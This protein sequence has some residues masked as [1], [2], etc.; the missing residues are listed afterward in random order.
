MAKID[1]S[2]QRKYTKS[3]T[4]NTA[5]NLQKLD[6]NKI[7][8]KMPNIFS[9]QNF[10]TAPV[11]FGSSP[12]VTATT[13]FA[14][15]IA[16]GGAITTYV[17]PQGLVE[18]YF[19]ST[20]DANLTVTAWI[21]DEISASELYSTLA[22]V[23]IN[24]TTTSSVSLAAALPAGTNNIGD[25]DIASALPA[26]SNVIGG[27]T[28]A[29]GG[30]TT[31]GAKAD[32]AITNP[33]SSGSM[34]AFLKG[35]L[36]TLL[37]GV[38]LA[39][40]SNVVGGVTIADGG[41]TT[42]GAKADAKATSGTGTYSIVALLKGLLDACLAPTPAGTNNI[43]DVDVLTVPTTITKAE[44]VAIYN[45]TMTNANQEYSQALPAGTKSFSA[46][47]QDGD[48]SFNVRYAFVTGKVATPTAPYLKYNGAVEF[49]SDELHYDSG[50]LYFACSSAGKV[51][52]II[53]WS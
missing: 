8:N 14:G 11:Y 46:S 7:D 44:T 32:A 40:G 50:T 52:Q 25:V 20:A 2:T 19:F 1:K 47:I 29:D 33:A 21:G 22:T 49:S 27:V 39:A 16:S 45:V 17:D 34:I 38:K 23:I 12:L 35:I 18:M 51:M 42:T 53:A 13:N 30:D 28:I 43:G 48:S 26:G 31:T 36:S 4:G 3:I 24:S 37:N 15:S 41:D 10:G 6:F 5:A 9:I